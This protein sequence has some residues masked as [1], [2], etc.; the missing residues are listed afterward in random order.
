M[1]R[2][3][4]WAWCVSALVAMSAQVSFGQ[5]SPSVLEYLGNRASQLADQ[6]P[7]IPATVDAWEKQRADLLTRLGGTLGLPAREPM[8][9]AINYSKPDG[10]LVIEEVAYLWAERAYVSATVIRAKQ[11]AGRRPAI[12]MPT[13]WLGH[14]TFRPY[15]KFVEHL[16]RQGFVILFSDDPRT[17]Q[18]QAPAAGLYAAASAAGLQV[19][20]IQVFDALRGFDY[21]LTRP[22]VD[23]GK[24]GLV[25]LG[26]GA[27]QAYLAAALEPRFQFVAAV[28]GTLTC[29]ALVKA[30][31]KGS[32]PEDPSAMA[33]GLLAF[34]D[35][36]RVAASL[37]PRPLLIA[38]SV[39]GGKG[40][41]AGHRKALKTIQA[42]YGLYH[43]EQQL[44]PVTGEGWDDLTPLAPEIA[45]WLDTGVLPSLKGSDASPASCGKPENPDFSML[46]YLQ[47]RIASE[48]AARTVE[49]VAPA[50]A[51]T[52]RE[53]LVSWLRQACALDSLKPAA[54]QLGKVTEGD[55]WVSEQLA[56]GVD[57]NFHCPAVL[58]RPAESGS[59]KRGAVI[60]SHDDRQCAASGRIA[61]SARQLAAAGYLVLVPDHASADPQ[62]RQSLADPD[63][64]SFYGDEAAK[65][66][67]SGEA[68]GLS[69]L[70][71]RVAE[72]L[73]A[74][75]YLASRPE[76]DAA[77]IV[78]AGL[79]IGGVDAA[80][81]ALL[82]KRAAGVVSLDATTLRDWV[83]NV[84]P[85][86]LR[87]YHVLPYLPSLLRMA[88]LD[89]CYGALAPQSLLLVRLKDGWP[90]S[91]F[92]QVAA[93]AA[94]SY[95]VQQADK[96]LLAL[97]ARGVL[98]QAE[99]GRAEGVQK[100]L[101]AIARTLVPTPPQ[102]G[103]VGNADGVKQRRTTDSARG[104]IWVA[105]ELD[106]YDQQ[107]TG[108]GFEL[109]TWSWFNRNGA[110]QQGFAVTPLIFKKVGDRYELTGIGQ[111][112]SNAGTGLQTFAFEPVAGTATVGDDY[113]FGWHDGPLDGKPNAGVVEFEDAPDSRMIILTGDGQMD[114][115]KLKLG[116]TYHAQ[117]EFR[118]RY[119]IMA[120]SKKP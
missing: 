60:L 111:T 118:R 37:A 39:P 114:G 40:P 84:A 14:W 92:E 86:Q 97:D 105:G 73:A 104:L 94:A 25:G 64:P 65:L 95:R 87:F 9:A 99:A 117:S 72:D 91:G 29:E 58:V 13:G 116:A 63:Q 71:L 47:R 18:R 90:R 98:D 48:A 51:G 57:A 89:A 83:V 68:V 7:A 103:L 115:Q 6:L 61:E 93:T 5:E 109:Q 32:G 53:E 77:K 33:A 11:A 1:L 110:A 22:D 88:D 112:R 2:S 16:A 79:G 54:D 119:S 45:R 34:T 82:E 113:F 80:L 106:G 41:A 8:Q 27:V 50:A 101:L 75:R 59:T 102:A 10:E 46:G 81:S 19:T 28:G 85:G 52:R 3:T 76:A 96:S 36:D 17:G 38:G 107:F 70:A 74:F 4:C 120:V 20:G 26:E 78:I 100:Q 62:S 42:V 21:L 108:T 49:P 35:L 56:L 43:A 66:Y 23:P 69:P 30:T 24:I 31:A 44:R 12:V 55:G 15:R 67:G